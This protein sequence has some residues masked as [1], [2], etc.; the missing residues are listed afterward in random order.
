MSTGYSVLMVIA[1]TLAVFTILFLSMIMLKALGKWV[2]ELRQK[3]LEHKHKRHEQQASKSSSAVFDERVE[4]EFSNSEELAAI[5]M[6]LHFYLNANRDEES[7]IIT[8][9][10]PQARYSPWAQ[11]NLVIK[12]VERR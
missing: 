11:K 4:D 7:E 2:T 5:T 6:A 3:N 10:M 1:A 9:E 8:I 12:R